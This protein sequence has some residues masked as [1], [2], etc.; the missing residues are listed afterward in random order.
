MDPATETIVVSSD[1]ITERFGV[2]DACWALIVASRPT[3]ACVVS[4]NTLMVGDTAMPTVPP[5]DAATVNAMIS[6]VE[7]ALTLASPPAFATLRSPIRASTSSTCTSTVLETP[8]PALLP[9]PTDPPIIRAS[10]SLSE[11]TDSLPPDLSVPPGPLGVSSVYALVSLVRTCTA[12]DAATAT[13][14]PPTPNV[15]AMDVIS[16]AESALIVRSPAVAS[17]SA[18]DPTHAVVLR[19]ITPTFRPIPTP[20]PPPLTAS[21]PAALNNVSL[22]LAS[23]LRFCPA[24]TVES[25]SI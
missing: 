14:P 13:L 4:D 23:T 20:E 9:T 5:P 11:V 3:E 12:M 7:V 19:S 22:S 1:A 15:A 2:P 8:T 24:L 10:K 16:S 21:P 17:T 18:P 25:S 6:S